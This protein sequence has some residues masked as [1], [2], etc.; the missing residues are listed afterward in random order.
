MGRR[1]PAVAR[2]LERVT[3]TARAHD[4]FLPGETVLVAVSG[5]PDSICM[6]HALHALRRLFKIKLEVFHFDHRLREDSASDA[7]YV[8]RIADRLEL[9]FHLRVAEDQPRRGASVE[10]WAHRARV[11]ALGLALRDCGASKAAIG[12]TRDDQAEQVLLALL[13]GGGL[14]A[15][16]GLRP[17]RGPHVRPLLEVTREDVEA[18]DRELHLRAR[19]DTSND[20]KRFLRNAIR[21]EVLPAIAEATGRDARDTIARTAGLLRADADELHLR[22]VRAADDVLTDGPDGWSIDAEAL[23]ALPSSIAGRVVL[24]ALYRAGYSPSTEHVLA[25]LDLA[26]GRPGRTR[27]L[28]GGTRARRERGYIALPSANGET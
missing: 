11:G 18:M 3:K 24:E 2:V 5:G 25:V 9:P 15:L 23:E 8:R 4:M 19:H 14:D 26:E 17:T 10:D 20:D 16:A 6:V 1:P 12:H 7:R 21:H 13:R 28:P 22:A 27:D